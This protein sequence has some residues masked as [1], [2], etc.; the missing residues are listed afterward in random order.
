MLG[1]LEESLPDEASQ[2]Q[3]QEVMHQAGDK[4]AWLRD[5]IAH[6]TVLK[7]QPPGT[8]TETNPPTE[9][10]DDQLGT[11]GG[12]DLATPGRDQPGMEGGITPITPEDDK[13]LE[14]GEEDLSGAVT[15]SRAVAESLSKINMDS[16]A[17]PMGD[18]PGGNQ[19]A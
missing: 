16:P 9:E 19:D 1:V 2:S 6:H 15:P 17:P 12:T 3:S 8:G 4:L 13:L 10:A 14:Y 11:V 18:L 7:N 5:T